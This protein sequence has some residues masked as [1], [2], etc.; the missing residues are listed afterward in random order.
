MISLTAAAAQKL[1]GLLEKRGKP[2][3]FLRLR[4]SSGGCSG[5]SLAFDLADDRKPEDKVYESNGA[6]VVIDP[7]SEFFLFG[8]TVDYESSLIKSGFV[9]KNPTATSTCGCGAS[10]SV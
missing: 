10:F 1:R 6:K 3:G 2:E 4:V 9:A 7:K 8:S 5:M